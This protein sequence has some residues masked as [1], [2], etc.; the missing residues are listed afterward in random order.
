MY[1]YVVDWIVLLWVFD[2]EMDVL[3]YLLVGAA[4]V[5]GLIHLYEG[6]VSGFMLLVFAGAGFFGGIVVYTID[7]Y[8]NFLVLASIPF[9]LVQF[10]MYYRFY[11]FSLGPLGALDK[12]VQ[13]VFV[14]AGVFYL[15]L[16]LD[17]VGSLFDV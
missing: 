8:R 10:V 5:S 15:Y 14:L 2:F 3:D 1:F 7:L 16:N 13:L 17:G 9:T 4:A 12:V 6:F 11:G